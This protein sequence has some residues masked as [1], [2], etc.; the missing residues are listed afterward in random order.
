MVYGAL[1]TT[2]A[3]AALLQSD[4]GGFALGDF[5][6][7]VQQAGPLR[8]PIFFVLALGLVQVF[9]KLFELV[10][11]RRVSARLFSV[12]VTSSVPVLTIEDVL[13]GPVNVV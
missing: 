9:L 10:R 2:S 1:V 5:W 12:D 6:S 3:T 11:D 13:D 4:P 7:L 8:W